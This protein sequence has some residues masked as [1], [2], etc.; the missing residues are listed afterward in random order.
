M[1]VERE[2]R[3]GSWIVV[4]FVAI[5]AVLAVLAGCG[6]GDGDTPPAEGKPGIPEAA[7]T[8]GA[9]G[10]PGGSDNSGRGAKGIPV[11]LAQFNF[12]QGDPADAVVTDIRA[13]MARNCDEKKLPVDCVTVTKKAKNSAP[14]P[15]CSLAEDGTP[16]AKGYESFV[17]VDPP[18]PSAGI[19]PDATI[20]SGGVITVYTKTCVPEGTSGSGTGQPTTTTT[21]TKPPATTA[22]PTTSR[23]NG[24]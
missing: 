20:E 18:L 17:G 4:V 22:P 8:E 3:V 23:R 11:D 19:P 12:S 1:G 24:G 6:D 7:A 21:T 13:Q 10:N 14:T 5:A 2:K 15:T 9:S 16:V